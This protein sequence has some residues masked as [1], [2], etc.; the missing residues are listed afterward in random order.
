MSPGPATEPHPGRSGAGRAMARRLSWGLADQAVSSLTNFAVGIY[1]ARSLGV[2]AFGIFSL[3][4]VTYAVVLSLSRGLA[5][6]PLLVRFSGV[7]ISRWRPA[8]TQSSSTALLVGLGTGAASLLAG[9]FIGGV[10]GSAFVALGLVLPALLLQDSWRYAFFAGGRG[11][12]AFVNDAVWAVALVPALLLADRNGSVFTFVLAWGAAGAVAAGYGIVQTRVLPV[13]HGIRSWLAQHRDLGLRYMVENVSMT[14]AEQLRMYGLGA[15][16]GLAAVGAVRGAQLLLAPFFAILLAMGLV[17]V[18][19]AARV[20]KRSPRRLPLFCLL[21]GG[22]EAVAGAIWGLALLFLLP[23]EVGRELLGSVWPSA[24]AL[25]VPTTLV[26]MGGGLMDGASAGLRALGAARR[27][28]RAKLIG[29]A[30]Y[31][32]CGL[33]GAVV[34]GAAGAVWGV[35]VA[36]YFAVIINWWQFLAAMGELA[37]ATDESR[38]EMETVPS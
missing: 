6:D 35:A 9:L 27:S 16:A 12:D 7:P 1:V 15:I 31:V 18:P 30:A 23:A 34:G 10:V 38:L 17:S 11:R 20:L 36:I 37:G 21:L 13:V 33:A 29:A 2:T 14:S 19:E 5:T 8:V 28:L 3:A 25:V 4:W 24:Y 22:G 26:F 32:S